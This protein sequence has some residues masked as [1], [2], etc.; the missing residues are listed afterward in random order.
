MIEMEGI[1][2]EEGRKGEK[3][4]V[5]NQSTRRHYFGIVKSPQTV[6]VN[7]D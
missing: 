3:I 5:Y 6:V 4:R 7:L 2:K 1:A